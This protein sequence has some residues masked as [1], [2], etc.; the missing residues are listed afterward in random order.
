MADLLVKLYDLRPAP[1]CPAGAQL[2]KPIGAEHA[3]VVEWMRQRFGP[4]W[5]SE[6]AVALGNRPV[7]CWLALQGGAL[8]GVALYDA[9]AR[10]YFGPIGVDA[11][12]RGR[13]L[14]RALLHA[15]LADMA[16]A[17]YGYAIVGGVGSDAQRRFY[18]E[19][20][21]ATVIDGSEPGLYRGMLR[22]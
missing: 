19:A 17:G 13:G 6:T 2:R 9:T 18:G 8:A 10:G 4:G 5:A 3:V 7:S 11:A 20:A 16:A 21:G 14:G 22:G 1:P 15:V 12:A